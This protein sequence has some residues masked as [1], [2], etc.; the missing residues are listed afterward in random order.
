[1]PDIQDIFLKYIP[2]ST[3][4]FFVVGHLVTIFYD[5]Y[6]KKR[7]RMLDFLDSQINEF[8]GPLY[9]LTKAGKSLT[10]DFFGKVNETAQFPDPGEENPNA[11]WR[12]W[13]ENVFMPL[14]S[15]IEKI[16]LEKWYLIN[17]D[18]SGGSDDLVKFMVHSSEWKVLIKK[19]S[20]NDFSDYHTETAYPEGIIRYAEANYR[21][22]RKRQTGLRKKISYVKTGTESSEKDN[23][24]PPKK[25]VMHLSQ[26][27]RLFE[28][29]KLYKEKKDYR[30]ALFM[31]FMLANCDL[32]K[33]QQFKLWD[34]FDETFRE[35]VYGE[36]LVFSEDFK[37]KDLIGIINYNGTYLREK[38]G[39]YT[40]KYYEIPYYI[41]YEDK[42]FKK[43]IERQFELYD[44]VQVL[45][46]M[47]CYDKNRNFLY[48]DCQIT[49]QDN[50]KGWIRGADLWLIPRD[51]SKSFSKPEGGAI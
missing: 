10:N 33:K 42:E 48:C 29:A 22:L 32:T 7:A 36:K 43:T 37:T 40:Q 5:R 51:I 13:V 14:N 25:R 26:I 8:Y 27:M 49:T 16:I 30:N 39:E 20:L 24:E 23:A 50:Q 47:P 4:F 31:L 45:D 41:M 11:E 18:A 21:K 3:L 17:D 46:I 9:I 34:D 6:N 19:W 12:L 28:H 1:M 44:E 35:Y 2:V 15:K 38:K